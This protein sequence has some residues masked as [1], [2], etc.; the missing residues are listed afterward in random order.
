[1]A[2][3]W[4]FSCNP[5]GWDL[6][7]FLLSGIIKDSFRLSRGTE[8]RI[9][10]G[11]K[12]YILLGNDRR[13]EEKREFNGALLRKIDAGI[14]AEV[15]VISCPVC[16]V[17]ERDIF[18]YN[19][20]VG[21]NSSGNIYVYLKFTKNLLATPITRQSIRA[22]GIISHNLTNGQ[23]ESSREITKQVFN[24]VQNIIGSYS[25]PDLNELLS[26][27]FEDLDSNKKIR[28]LEEKLRN[29]DII[30]K[31]R[32]VNII[33]RSAYADT[34]KKYVNYECMICTQLNLKTNTFRKFKN[35][36]Y[37]DQYVEAHHVELI[38]GLIRGSNAPSNIAILC[39]VHH[40]Q[41]HYGDGSFTDINEREF[42][43]SINGKPPIRINKIIDRK[44]SR[45]GQNSKGVMNQEL[46]N[47]MR[48]S[49]T[50]DEKKNDIQKI[51]T[52]HLRSINFIPGK[53]GECREKL[54][55]WGLPPYT[56]EKDNLSIWFTS[57][58]NHLNRCPNNR[59][60]IIYISKW[61]EWI[62]DE[63]SHCFDV[64]ESR[65]VKITCFVL[66]NNGFVEHSLKRHCRN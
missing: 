14:Y 55:V 41:I 11:D 16:Q 51:L 58:C 1:M 28:I 62:P 46:I 61:E 4:V 17:R 23:Q 21:L 37:G 9:Q 49:S 3:Y 48:S 42:E 66:I 35:G 29:Q 56:E 57:M 38:S 45:A 30:T 64:A 39:P 63:F 34:L 59:E 36:K 24:E 5:A 50:D 10:I 31:N 53:P 27:S 7:K 26:A 54:V 6:Q 12:G 2:R 18:S 19:H 65:G 8:K 20:Q 25:T 47:I 15:E 40:K 22:A 33:E 32:M 13:T 43:V 52:S 44:D 60:A